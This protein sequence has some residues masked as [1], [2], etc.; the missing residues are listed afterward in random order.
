MNHTTL[1]SCLTT[2]DAACDIIESQWAFRSKITAAFFEKCEEA[3]NLRRER[4]AAT[5]ELQHVRNIAVYLQKE[6]SQIKIEYGIYEHPDLVTKQ[7]S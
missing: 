1:Q 2:Y 3:R 6:L 7:I 4:D 5:T